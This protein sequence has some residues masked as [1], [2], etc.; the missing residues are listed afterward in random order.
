MFRL[1]LMVFL[2]SGCSLFR[3]YMDPNSSELE[4][5]LIPEIKI[6][7]DTYVKGEPISGCNIEAVLNSAI[8]MNGY[9]FG[10]KPVREL[11]TEPT[12]YTINAD[13]QYIE[14]YSGYHDLSNLAVPGYGG[15]KVP[16]IM[17]LYVELLKDGKKVKGVTRDLT[18]GR[19]M[20]NC[21]RI[22]HVA[23]AA[24]VYVVHWGSKVINNQKSGE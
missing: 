16:T 14:T 12:Q 13:I 11:S 8:D 5:V 1:F 20:N 22:E 18:T 10:L 24:G 15:K 7:S 19:I 6:T 23:N 4:R 3:E 17:V 9:K 2:I 21:E